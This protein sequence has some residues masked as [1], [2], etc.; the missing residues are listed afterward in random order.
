M[1]DEIFLGGCLTL[2]YE[3]LQIIDR[4]RGNQLN[5]E[6]YFEAKKS[7]GGG[8]FASKRVTK[9]LFCNPTV[10]LYRNHCK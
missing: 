5:D 10:I 8:N 9:Y 2:F 6:R 7:I 3:I 4:E 1:L